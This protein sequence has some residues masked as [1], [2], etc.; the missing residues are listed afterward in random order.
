MP[1]EQGKFIRLFGTIFFSILGAIVSFVLLMLLFRLFLSSLDYIPWF[2]YFY[3]SLV[4]LLPTALFVSI[5]IIFFKRTKS[6]PSKPVRLFSNAVFIAGIVSW[7]VVLALDC[8][9]FF[10][11]VSEEINH[12]YSFE[13]LFLAG[14]VAIIFLIGIIQALTTAKEKDWME[15]RVN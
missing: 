4:L 7:F 8:I 9:N 13:L 15:K 14:N 12:Y 6:H 10:K 1:E 3:M 5:Y 2:T 11:T